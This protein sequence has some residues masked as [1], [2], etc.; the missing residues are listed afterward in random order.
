MLWKWAIDKNRDAYLVLI[1]KVSGAYEGTQET[2]YYELSWKNQLI[3][4][5][6]DF[7]KQTFDEK[8]ATMHWR[9]HKLDIPELLLDQHE[10][11]I[12]LIKEAFRTVGEFFDGDRYIA[13]EVEFNITS[14]TIIQS[15]K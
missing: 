5:A 13:V 8:R 6:S 4:I 9:I 10:D 14:Y 2:K 12:N 7:L 11:V 3:S 15:I 1:N